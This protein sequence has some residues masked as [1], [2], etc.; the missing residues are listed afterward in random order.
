V[1]SEFICPSSHRD[2]LYR[3]SPDLIATAQPYARSDYGGMDGER[4]LRSPT[5]TN[6]PERG[7]MI[8]ASNIALK[9]ITDGSSQTIQIAECPEGI[10]AIWISVKN[11]FD[12]SA[13]INTLAAPATQYYFTDYAQEIDSYHA[14]GA[15]ALMADGSVHFFSETMDNHTL[16]ALCSRAGNDIMDDPY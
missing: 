14:G 15:S 3:Q 11:Y 7:T 8:L 1:L 5:G 10:S 16:S 6:S 13:P 12:Q 2:S 4:L 9:D